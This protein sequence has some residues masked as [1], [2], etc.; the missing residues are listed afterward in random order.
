MIGGAV[1][2]GLWSA[3]LTDQIICRFLLEHVWGLKR[4]NLLITVTGGAK[5]F[6][7]GNEQKDELLQGLTEAVRFGRLIVCWPYLSSF[8]WTGKVRGSLVHHWRY[9]YRSVVL[10]LMGARLRCKGFSGE[11]CSDAG[12][13]RFMGEA[14]ALYAN[15]IPLIGIAQW[16]VIKGRQRLV[17]DRVTA[18]KVRFSSFPP[19]FYESACREFDKVILPVYK[20]K[21]L[22]M[23]DGFVMV[24][25]LC[26]LTRP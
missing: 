26:C 25:Q 11:P 22:P 23:E 4:P 20:L 21:T 5:D 14:R 2:Y 19:A 6:E 16:G 3:G 12:I 17:C 1:W 18:S 10:L 9:G 13:M 15:H 8:S 24:G 7:L